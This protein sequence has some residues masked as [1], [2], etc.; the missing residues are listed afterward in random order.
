[1]KA[2]SRCNELHP[3]LCDDRPGGERP[4]RCALPKGHAGPHEDERLREPPMV[5]DVAWCSACGATCEGKFI[6]TWCGCVGLPGTK[7][8]RVRYQLLPQPR[9][10]KAVTP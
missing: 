2:A 6:G 3:M 4:L 5:I 8:V 10:R 9:P 1:M 7:L